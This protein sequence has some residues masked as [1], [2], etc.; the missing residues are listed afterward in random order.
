MFIGDTRSGRRNR[1]LKTG[2]SWLQLAVYLRIF[3]LTEVVMSGY[4]ES[5]VH[6]SAFSPVNFLSQSSSQFSGS[7]DTPWYC[8]IP[9]PAPGADE[10]LDSI[11]MGRALDNFFHTLKP[12]DRDIVQRVFWQGESQANVA[13]AFGVSSMAI[14]KA[15]TRIC[16]Q[17]AQQ[18]SAFRGCEMLR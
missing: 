12:R 14:S 1:C 13:R 3:N 6:P 17:G 5:Y 16:R 4:T 7:E 10:V 18:L 8:D 2:G 11:R 9:D 15:M